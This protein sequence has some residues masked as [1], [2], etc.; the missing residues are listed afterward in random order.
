[1]DYSNE[2]FNQAEQQAADTLKDRL[3]RTPEV[4]IILGSGL[5]PVAEHAN[6]ELELDYEEIPGFPVSTVE[7]HAG[8]LLFGTLSG[9]DVLL[10]KGR[11]HY[12]EGHDVRTTV[13]PVKLAIRL[14]I[15]RVILTN[16]AGGIDEDGKPG[17]LMLIKDHLSFFL[18]SPLRGAND[19][20]LGPRFP[21]MSRVYTEGLRSLAKAAASDLGIELREGVYAY[22][23]GPQF[24]TPAEIR[25]LRV[26]GANA[27]GM[28]TV[29]EAIV[30]AHAGLEVLGISSITNLAA[31]ITGQP[32]NHEEVLEVGASISEKASLLIE[33]IV[34]R[35][36]K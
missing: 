35:L 25:A 20:N 14:G 4:A 12:Y 21:D 27:A 19:A 6:V 17:D 24:E 16:A 31:G 32:L 36:P 5:G 33:T 13:F 9:R 26:L 29:A 2:K 1:M 7:G 10:F 23:T 28:S 8:K 15:P 30:A 18:P 22:M 34:A 3:P 11:F